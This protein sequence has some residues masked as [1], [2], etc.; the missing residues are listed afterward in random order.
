MAR[1]PRNQVALG[2]AKKQ[3][4]VVL[5][6]DRLA[7]YR[8]TLGRV[9]QALELNNTNVGGGYVERGP[10]QY[11]IR[12]EGQLHTVEDIGDVET[13]S[14]GEAALRLLLT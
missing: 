3:Y 5:N 7:A 14:S 9:L 13:A 11:L 12:G 10:E 6:R 1:G 2:G 4:E 8:I